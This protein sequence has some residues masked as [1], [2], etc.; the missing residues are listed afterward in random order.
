MVVVSPVIHWVG[1]PP[2]LAQCQLGL[3]F[4]SLGIL[5]APFRHGDC[6][7]LCG[8]SAEVISFNGYRHQGGY[9]FSCVFFVIRIM[10]KL[11]K[12]VSG[13]F[14]E[15]WGETKGRMHWNLFQ[16]WIRDRSRNIV[17]ILS[18][19]WY[20]A[21]LT[22]SLTSQRIIHSSWCKKKSGNNIW[23][24]VIWCSV[25]G[26]N[27]V[28]GVGGGVWFTE[29]YSSLLFV[30]SVWGWID[31]QTSIISRKPVTIHGNIQSKV[32]T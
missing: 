30:L 9:V 1:S 21:Y 6:F 2:L 8:C 18:T 27:W 10:Q 32:F 14:V 11:L 12:Q 24:C 28:L 7:T 23:E 20:R 25:I 15:Q 29:W 5:C 4:V 31:F 26:F 13:N 17:L 16:I 3:A 19:L 22:F